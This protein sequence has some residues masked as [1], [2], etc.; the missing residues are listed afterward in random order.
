[1]GKCGSLTLAGL[2]ERAISRPTW[3]ILPH[4]RTAFRPRELEGKSKRKW[5]GQSLGFDKNNSKG[6]ASFIILLI[7]GPSYI[8]IY[9]RTLCQ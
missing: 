5:A 9:M 3:W 7:F 8:P 1:M 4:G 6:F 2:W